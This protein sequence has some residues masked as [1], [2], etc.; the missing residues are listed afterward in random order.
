M[1]NER[2]EKQPPDKELEPQAGSVLFM[3]TGEAIDDLGMNVGK[4]P[5]N[6]FRLDISKLVEPGFA[7]RA[8]IDYLSKL[9]TKL[10]AAI[11]LVGGASIM[12]ATAGATLLSS[13]GKAEPPG[14]I[15]KLVTAPIAT[16]TFSY[17]STEDKRP[18]L[19]FSN[20]DWRPPVALTSEDSVADWVT[21]GR[22]IPEIIQIELEALRETGKLDPTLA[23]I[24]ISD[25][26]GT[27]SAP[28]ERGGKPE[29]LRVATS[30]DA[31]F[32]TTIALVHQGSTRSWMPWAGVFHKQGGEWGYRDLIVPG[33]STYRTP[34]M[35]AISVSDIPF[36]YAKAFP[37]QV[38]QPQPQPQY[39]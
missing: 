9:G 23:M 17:P 20:L 21:H 38:V 36:A 29:Y 1:K 5:D 19:D 12:L 14:F 39:R 27:W 26:R 30:G 3:P 32:V 2:I 15:E 6:W 24:P 31:Y 8:R 37:A 7:W 18:R 11:V 25:L 34:G 22:D 4:L 28:A 33:V 35:E 13:K 16:L 10:A